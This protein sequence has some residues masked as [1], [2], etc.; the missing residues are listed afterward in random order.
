MT[1]QHGNVR[2]LRDRTV[3]LRNE[4]GRIDMLAGIA[5]DITLSRQ[6][7]AE[8][9]DSGVG[10]SAANAD[11]LF[12]PFFTTKE[13]GMGIGLSICKTIVEEHGGEI[14]GR[15]VARICRR[16]LIHSKSSLDPILS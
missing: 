11:R 13:N 4:Q 16:S 10:L 2:W 15:F 14:R 6:I 1:D 3:L 7:A 12:E 8:M 9:G 5:E